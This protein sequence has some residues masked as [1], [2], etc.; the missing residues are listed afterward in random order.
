MLN[1]IGKNPWIHSLV[2]RTRL[3]FTE[4]LH[5]ILLDKLIL[6]ASLAQWNLLLLP[7]VQSILY[8][9]ISFHSLDIFIIFIWMP[10]YET[11]KSIKNR[12]S[13]NANLSKPDSYGS[14][15]HLPTPETRHPVRRIFPAIAGHGLPPTDQSRQWNGRTVGPFKNKQ[16]NYIGSLMILQKYD[17]PRTIKKKYVLWD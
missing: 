4:H 14:P 2:W 16:W 7:L 5:K 1:S 15:S 17:S 11:Y 9:L 12:A 6:D 13:A 10:S 8:P 3:E